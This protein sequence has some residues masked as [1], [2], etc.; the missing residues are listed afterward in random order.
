MKNKLYRSNPFKTGGKLSAEIRKNPSPKL[1]ETMY[2]LFNNKQPRPDTRWKWIA[3]LGLMLIGLGFSLSGEAIIWKF[4][5]VSAWEWIALGTL[6]LC[7]LNA[8]VS[9][10]GKAIVIQVRSERLQPPHTP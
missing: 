9:V 1:Q 10:F 8:G 6:G 5:E 4:Q 2:Q 3:P 7:I